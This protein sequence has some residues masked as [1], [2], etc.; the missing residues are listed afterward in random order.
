MDYKDGD[1]W[2]VDLLNKYEFNI[3]PIVNPDG[4]A[5][6]YGELGV[7]TYAGQTVTL[8]AVCSAVF[9]LSVDLLILLALA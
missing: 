9:S 4:Y 7:R 2:T 5:Y 6:T 1:E 8:T 3:V